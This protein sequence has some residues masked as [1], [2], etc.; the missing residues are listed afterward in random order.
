M[1]PEL[2]FKDEGPSDASSTESNLTDEGLLSVPF[3][4]TDFLLSFLTSSSRIL[5]LGESNE[6]CLYNNPDP[7]DFVRNKLY[8]DR[9]YIHS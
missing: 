1:S 9:E 2:L 6:G 4:P 7:D 3:L 8:R 5:S